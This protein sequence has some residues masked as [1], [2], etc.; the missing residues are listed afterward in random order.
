MAIDT[1]PTIS[2][3]ITAENLVA[4]GAA[5]NDPA[6][7]K[8]TLQ[9]GIKAAQSGNRSQARILLTQAAELDPKSENAWLW[10]A[11]ISEYPEELLGFLQHVLD[12]NPENERALEWM[13]A[14][15]SLLAKTFVQRGIDALH[16]KQNDYAAE[17]FDQ[18]L[19]Y[20]QQNPLAWL[21]K[22]SLCESAPDKIFYLERAVELDP[23]NRSALLALQAAKD[24]KVAIALNKAKA[25]AVDG[26]YEEAMESLDAF[27]DTE[28]ECAEAWLLRSHLATDFDEKIMCL[29]RVLAADPEHESARANREWLASV[30]ETARPAPPAVEVVTQEMADEDVPMLEAVIVSD[31]MIT[32]DEDVQPS[33]SFFEHPTEEHIPI[34]EFYEHVDEPET[35]AVHFETYENEH[36]PEKEPAGEF[37]EAAQE[38][39]EE[40][41][42]EVHTA[43]TFEPVEPADP[44]SSFDPVETVAKVEA[45]ESQVDEH[46][47]LAV[48]AFAETAIE[49]DIYSA[50]DDSESIPMPDELLDEGPV[51][52]TAAVFSTNPTNDDVA[53]ADE[54]T[55]IEFTH[56]ESVEESEP[57]APSVT[58]P[59]EH[60]EPVAVETEC[61]FCGSRNV[62]Q[63]I[64]C[65]SCKS[66]LT[67]SDLET[68]LSNQG[69]DKFLLRRALNRMESKTSPEA[70]SE[71]ELTSLALG[72]LNLRDWELG[73]SFLQEASHANPNN[74]FLG[75]QANSLLIRLEEMKQQEEA[76]DKMPK[77]KTILVVDDSPT[78]CKLVAGKLEKS[79]HEVFCSNDGPQALELLEGLV[80]DL[81]LLDI[82]MPK[83][84]GYQVCKLIRNNHATQN[85][86]V[87]MISGKDG[88]FDKVRGRMAGTTG[89]I[90]KPFG[91]ETLMKA[92]ETFLKGESLETDQQ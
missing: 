17:C 52:A 11:S 29:D 23:D 4:V 46:E 38:F 45:V 1:E 5:V 48:D 64:S 7:A 42:F 36:T 37:A 15:K 39:V 31:D 6:D 91:P 62:A 33:T 90:T 34:E 16:D 74:V 75:S 71:E 41:G 92:V 14:T 54:S 20:D 8:E 25:A 51:V 59:A 22:A 44:E 28:F 60:H 78:V 12:I 30:V 58:A 3:T 80:P 79:G 49:F 89:Y 13:V 18:A 81:V 21:W 70:R 50:N 32:A 63:S 57:E 26:R 56:E 83:M 40:P 19:A 35:Q 68:L 61:P 85:V 67:L 2:G 43:E 65:Y 66:V 53:A 72:Y 27:L 88:F 76:R 73:L 24:Q 9:N 47:P 55:T 77:G 69:S 10:L 84:D 82:N 87:V 86:P